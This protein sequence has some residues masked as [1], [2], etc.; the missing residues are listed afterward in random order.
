M[1]NALSPGPWCWEFHGNA[2]TLCDATGR[3]ILRASGVREYD[4]VVLQSVP[5][6]VAALRHADCCWRQFG[7]LSAEAVEEIRSALTKAG[8]AWADNAGPCSSIGIGD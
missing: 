3:K 4:A 1:Q 5:D 6:M 2:V 8:Q 7:Q